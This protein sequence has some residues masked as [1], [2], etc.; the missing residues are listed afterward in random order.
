MTKKDGLMNP[1]AM[2]L[3]MEEE[4]EDFAALLEESLKQE[5]Q[6]KLVKGT[7]VKITDDAVM[8]DVGAKIEGRLHASEILDSEGN[9]K[10]NEGDRSADERRLRRETFH[11]L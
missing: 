10:F 9:R 11:L 2:K 7:I 6:D 5:A 4:N 1:E 8:V 3:D